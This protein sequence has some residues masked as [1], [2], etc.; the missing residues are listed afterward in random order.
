MPQ[1]TLPDWLQ[2][3]VYFADWGDL[4][5]AVSAAIVVLLL[6]IWWQQQTR[7]WFRIVTGLLLSAL[8][9]CISSY[10]LFVV[11]VYF[12][13]CPE[14]CIGRRGYPMPI[15]RIE[16]DGR[17]V[18]MPLDFGLNLLLL[19]LLLLG[20]SL[21]WRLLGIGIRLWERSLRARLLFAFAVAVLP[22]ALLP[23]VF[24][25]PQPVTTGEDLRLANNARRQA[26]F[27]YDITGL[28]VQRLA[29]EDVEPLDANALPVAANAEKSRRRVCLRGYTYFYL[30]WRRYRIELEPSGVSAV[31]DGLT[32]IPLAGSCWK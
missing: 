21:I 14:G 5:L 27:T 2:D 4:L 17:I 16:L 29:L 7:Y 10:Y 23:R 20:A 25:P 32:E 15:A 28:W 24:N 18:T 26:E 30:P 1:I 22:W 8:L 13:G 3:A 31:K 9:L 11:P 12:V 19:W 6:I